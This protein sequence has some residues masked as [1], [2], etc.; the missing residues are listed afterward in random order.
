[1]LK[2]ADFLRIENLTMHYWTLRGYVKAVENANLSLAKGDALGVVGESG[3]GKTSVMLTILRLLP[4]NAEI[5]NGTIHLDGNDLLKMS[6]SEFRKKIRWRRISTVFQ[7]SM[8]AL[9]PMMK[10]GDQLVEPLLLHEKISRSEAR[11]R[12]K[13]LLELTGMEASR[14]E[15]YPHELSGGMKQRAV[16]AMSLTCNPDLVI[17]DEPT[18]A[19]DVIIAAQVME[20]LR[21][22]QNKL[23]ITLI[24]VTH[25]LSIVAE[26]C[27]KIAIMYAG[28]IVETGD[29]ASIFGD[30]AHP[31]SK[32]L[33]NAFPSILGPKRRLQAIE[34]SPPDLLEPP[35][36]CRFHPRCP[37]AMEICQ[38]KGPPPLD[39]GKNHVVACHLY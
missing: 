22:L 34:G 27:N 21:E 26:V 32:G 16:I 12:A 28:N 1:M 38:K 5:K 31:Y 9:H 35:L 36:G 10:I 17:A 19:L 37:N 39:L 24:I 15:R 25:D 18:T 2:E 23:G 4:R 30:P 29:T 11:K 14:S 7:G 13:K 8:N 33:I 6:L 3:C 20:L